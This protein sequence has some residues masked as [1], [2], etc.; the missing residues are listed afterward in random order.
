M[1]LGSGLMV[2]FAD[3][4]HHHCSSRLRLLE[5][6][7]AT[8]FTTAESTLDSGLPRYLPLPHF[9]PETLSEKSCE[10]VHDSAPA[11]DGRVCH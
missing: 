5:S 8:G 3:C 1:T 10:D 9:A 11:R 4:P 2:A 6:P 7:T